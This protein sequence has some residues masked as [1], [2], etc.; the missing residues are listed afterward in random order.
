[1]EI[2]FLFLCTLAGVAFATNQ[3]VIQAESENYED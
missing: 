2:L 1:M 3:K